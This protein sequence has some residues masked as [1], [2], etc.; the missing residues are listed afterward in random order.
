MP[1]E[2]CGGDEGCGLGDAVMLVAFSVGEG[3]VYAAGD[4]VREL[5]LR[6]CL[7]GGDGVEGLKARFAGASV[8][9]GGASVPPSTAP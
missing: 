8:Y 2:W 6:L 4:G 7:R 9:R 3:G 1:G 5:G